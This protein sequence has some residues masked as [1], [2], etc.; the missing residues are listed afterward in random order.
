MAKT[1]QKL[2]ERRKYI[3]LRAAIDTTYIVSETGK[4][5]TTT[6]K[7]LSVDGLRFETHDKDL[8][9][10]SIVELKLSIPGSTSPVHAKGKVVWKRKISLEDEAPYDIGIEFSSIEEDNKNT[11]LKYLCDLIYSL[12]KGE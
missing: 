6:T 8:K 4:M 9:E 3:R 7:D 1:P 12:P 2:T 5:Y 11:F 10:S